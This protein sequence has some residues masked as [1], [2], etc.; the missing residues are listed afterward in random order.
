VTGAVHRLYT[1]ALV[2]RLEHE[3]IVF[4]VGVVTRHFPQLEVIHV[5]RNDLTVTT[6]LVLMT[7]EIHQLVVDDGSVRVE[8][9]RAG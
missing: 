7:D 1:E 5:G 2:L 6:H 3:D 4:V 8:E 9:S